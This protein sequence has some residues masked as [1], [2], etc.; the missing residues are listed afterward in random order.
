MA[1]RNL[2]NICGLYN[3]S[4]KAK[5]RQRLIKWDPRLLS[6]K[7]KITAC[8]RKLKKSKTV[9]RVGFEEKIRSKGCTDPSFSVKLDI[10]FLLFL[11]G[12]FLATVVFI[13][14]FSSLKKEIQFVNTLF[15]CSMP[16]NRYYMP[17]N[18][19][20]MGTKLTGCMMR[21]FQLRI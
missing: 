9:G 12:Y 1:N 19:W 20:F 14:L 17:L 21:I 5:Q 7:A 4:W 15:Q 18:D 11:F 8:V 10:W 2:N 16:I 13:D 6:R 3:Y